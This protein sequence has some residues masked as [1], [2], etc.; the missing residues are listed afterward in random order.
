MT[1]RASFVE[2]A[3]WA[4]GLRDGVEVLAELHGGVN[5][6]WHV[7]TPSGE[8][9]VHQLLGLSDQVD[10][11]ERCAWVSALEVAALAAG[12]LAPAPV[13]VPNTGAATVLLPE[14][15]GPFTVH[16]WYDAA[17]I[18]SGATSASFAASL[19]ASLARLHTL[20]F[21][22][23][24]DA[25]DALDRRPTQEEWARYG[26]AAD[27]LGLSWG[28]AFLTA[29]PHLV[30]VLACVDGWDAHSAAARVSSHRDL[31][32]ANLLDDHGTAVLLDW[33]SAGPVLTSAEIGRTALDNLLC[34]DALDESL[35]RSYLGG[36]A[37]QASLPK[38][39]PDWCSLWIRGLVVF[40]EQC[41]RSLLSGKVPAGLA[42][43]QQKVVE[44]T[45]DELDRR[46]RISPSLVDQFQAALT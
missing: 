17:P 1:G 25:A 33:E 5:Q 44:W 10:A 30:A 36:Y 24:T 45:P 29:A 31:T 19:G 41:A 9:A 23:A 22:P 37:G 27:H 15:V 35:L 32:S 14:A 20:N 16:E 2:A 39:T 3:C 34:G 13:F 6:V 18:D 43:F 40:A 26:A 7:R 12:V 28:P 11:V 8:Y 21:P 42:E 4:F 38:V 46:L